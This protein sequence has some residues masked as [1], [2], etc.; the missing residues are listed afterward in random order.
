MI[1]V[2]KTEILLQNLYYYSLSLRIFISAVFN[3]WYGPLLHHLNC[4]LGN[5]FQIESEATKFVVG[6]QE[7]FLNPPLMIKIRLSN[8]KS[9]KNWDFIA[10]FVL[11]FTVFKDIYFSCV[12][13]I[14]G[15]EIKFVIFIL[16]KAWRHLN[17]F[18]LLPLTFTKDAVIRRTY[19]GL[20]N[21]S[22]F[23]VFSG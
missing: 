12:Q 14:C 9:A 8:D 22:Y 5:S 17:I 2:Q 15:G 16:R 6:D 1:K 3:I 10:E 13:C 20:G 7:F 23:K 4:I 18:F 21:C 11:L 19:V